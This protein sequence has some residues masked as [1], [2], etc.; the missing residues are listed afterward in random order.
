MSDPKVLHVIQEVPTPH[1][2]VLLKECKKIPGIRLIVWYNQISFKGHGFTDELAYEITE[3][4]IYK[5][6]GIDFK[7]LFRFIFKKERFLMVGW[8]NSTTRSILISSFLFRIPLN[9]WFDM[10]NDA[11]ARGSIKNAL[12]NVFYLLA[13]LAPVKV[14]CVGNA[15]VNYFIKRGFASTRLVNLPIFIDVQN[16]KQFYTASSAELQQEIG[17]ID[18]EFNIS[19]GSRLLFEKGYDLLVRAIHLLPEHIRENSKVYIIGKGEQEK[20][21]ANL[22]NELGLQDRIKMLAWLPTTSF[23]SLIALCDV[24]IH[25]ARFDAFGGTIFAMSVGTPVIGSTTAG[26]AID[27]IEEGKNGY[28]YESGDI[29]QLANHIT[30]C[31]ENRSGVLKEMG[32]KARKTALQWTPEN[33]A[34]IILKNCI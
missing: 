9:M 31:Y 15:T 11:T 28:L 34:M 22:V 10:P 18:S 19:A 16:D 6:N 8:S 30:W 17:F 33:G 5:K 4:S 2:N 23:M 29:Q 13:R 26:A 27:R 25:P 32:I 20:Q 21:L 7:L 3:P 12:R 24:F 14:F 1:N